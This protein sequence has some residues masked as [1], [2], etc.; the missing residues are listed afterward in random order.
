MNKTLLSTFTIAN[1]YDSEIVDKI[2]T[3]KKTISS[4]LHFFPK[5]AA[6]EWPPIPTTNGTHETQYYFTIQN[7]K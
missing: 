3:K 6:T 1:G 4:N 5:E 7:I 2:I